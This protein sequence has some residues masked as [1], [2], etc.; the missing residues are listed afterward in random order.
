MRKILLVLIAMSLSCMFAQ[1]NPFINALT[2]AN[3]NLIV[4]YLNN[5]NID[6]NQKT[7]ALTPYIA[8][9]TAKINPQLKLKILQYLIDRNVDYHE[10]W[11]GGMSGLFFLN[12]EDG[13]VLDYLVSKGLNVNQVNEYGHST[14]MFAAA[15]NKPDIIK[16]LIHNNANPQQLTAKQIDSV[17]FFSQRNLYMDLLHTNLEKY[18]SVKYNNVENLDYRKAKLSQYAVNQLVCIQGE[19]QKI[20]KVEGI[21]YALISTK[22]DDN[23]AS[24]FGNNIVCQFTA[25]PGYLEDDIVDLYSQYIGEYQF[26]NP[27]NGLTSYPK[28]LIEYIELK[29]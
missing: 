7:G 1:E 21:S 10:E 17:M 23:L 3:E 16:A 26:I 24:F 14:L 12:N 5:Q 19:I 18:K 29:K 28:F 6:V 2:T 13:I 25:A 11:F 22:Y 8:T 20:F 27:I 15:N 4:D 9:I